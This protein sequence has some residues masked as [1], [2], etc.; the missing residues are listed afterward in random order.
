MCNSLFTFKDS[1]ARHFYLHQL[2]SKNGRRNEEE[3]KERKKKRGRRIIWPV[4]PPIDGRY[5]R[6]TAAGSTALGTALGTS[7]ME[8]LPVASRA[9]PVPTP[10]VPPRPGWW[11]RAWVAGGT[12]LPSPVWPRLHCSSSCHVNPR[13]VVPATPSHYYR[14]PPAH[15]SHAPPCCHVDQGAG[16]TGQGIPM[17]RFNGDIKRNSF[18][19]KRLTFPVHLLDSIVRASFP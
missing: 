18:L 9:W 5:N 8:R 15:A 13:A 11:Y 4:V 2:V 19:L 16:T 10:V 12:S 17:A 7:K 3:N 1:I 6:Q 14:P